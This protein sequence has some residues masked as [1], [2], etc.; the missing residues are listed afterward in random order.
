MTKVPQ[1]AVVILN[2][3]GQNFLEKFLPS[4]T[5]STYPGLEIVVGDNAST[6]HSVQFMQEKYPAIRIIQNDKNYGFAEGYNKILEQLDSEYFIL[7]NS[8]VEVSPD[9]IEPV[10]HL[11]E[12]E[13]YIAAAQPK[14]LSY[15]KKDHFEYAGAAGGYLDALGYPFCRGRIFDTVEEDHGQYDYQ[16]EI[17]WASGAALFIKRKVLGRDRRT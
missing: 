7:L 12:S 5:A 17:F 4:V 16:S 1:V 10:I 15:S 9:W 2:W 3:N 8:D 14:I 6:D 11:M 13:M